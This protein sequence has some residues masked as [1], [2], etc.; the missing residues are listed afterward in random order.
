MWWTGLQ[1]TDYMRC[2]VHLQGDEPVVLSVPVKGELGPATQ[3]TDTCTGLLLNKIF[4]SFSVSGDA[5]ISVSFLH[6][7]LDIVFFG[8]L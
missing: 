2:S 3:W 7:F 8:A 5:L 4:F 6:L 1:R